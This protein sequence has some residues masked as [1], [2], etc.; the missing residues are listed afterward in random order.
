MRAT[1]E[2]SQNNFRC[3]AKELFGPTT[4]SSYVNDIWRTIDSSIRQFA[5]DCIIY[6]KITNKNDIRNLQKYLDTLGGGAVENEMKMNPGKSNA[7]RFTIALVKNP[8]GYCLGDQK[9]PG[10]EQL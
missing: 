3:A 6:R 4:V 1:I 9:N 5:D 2:G 8:L 7:I 10:I